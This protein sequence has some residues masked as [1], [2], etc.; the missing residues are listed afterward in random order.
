M[1]RINEIF[2]SLQGEGFHTGTPA[3]FVRFSGCNLQCHFCDTDHYSGTM[4]N[5]AEIVRAIMQYPLAPLIILTGGEPSLFIDRDFV[6]LLKHCTGKRVAIETNGTNTLPDNIDWVTLSPKSAYAG[7][8]T[9]PLVIDRCD[10]LK[11]VYTGQPLE[12]YFDIKAH[13]YFLQPCYC[14]DETQRQ[15]NISDTIQAILDDPRWRLSLQTH[16]YLHI[17]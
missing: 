4:M 7:G 12:P 1:K 16:R 14:A 6:D 5:E 2:Y 17:R 11:V 8:N 15:Q 10:E 13:H 9:F 3:V